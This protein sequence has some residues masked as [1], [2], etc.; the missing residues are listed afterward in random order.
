MKASSNRVL[1]SE[2]THGFNQLSAQWE[3]CLKRCY[4]CLHH[5]RTR[6]NILKIAN[7]EDNHWTLSLVQLSSSQ[8]PYHFLQNTFQYFTLIYSYFPPYLCA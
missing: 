2:H 4:C 7:T 3:M 1:L 5:S 6:I 8:P